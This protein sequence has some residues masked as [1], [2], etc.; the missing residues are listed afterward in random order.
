[1]AKTK[2]ATGAKQ[3][4]AKPRTRARRR[5]KTEIR[6]EAI[7]HAASLELCE[8]GYDAATISGIARRAGIAD[9]TI[10]KYVSDKR[11]LLFRV[12]SKS[13]E[14]H[15]NQ[16]IQGARSLQTA[17]EKIEFFCRQH[18]VFWDRN[19]ELSLLYAA[20]SRTRDRYHWPTYRENNR[21]YVQIVQDAIEE[22]V[23]NGDFEPSA[24]SR[25]LRDILIGSVEQ[26][27][28]GL[29]S[30]GQPIEPEKMAR[31]VVNVFL[32]GV[33]AK[34]EAANSEAAGLTDRLE[35]AIERLEGKGQPYNGRKQ[36]RPEG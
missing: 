10:Y 31:E 19:R 33:E 7:L 15:V 14:G 21:K 16:T 5:P 3:S 22:G 8:K 34:N 4:D 30:S 11:E 32:C 28:W 27:A 24:P 35:R 29:T 23:A 36:T 9:G 17:R 25:L 20:E 18:L 6:E 12:L 13:I 26:V 2:K 1:M